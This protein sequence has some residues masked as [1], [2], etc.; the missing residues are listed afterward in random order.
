MKEAA[1][2]LAEARAEM[3]AAIAEKSAAQEELGQV[4]LS[5]CRPCP[6]IPFYRILQNV[7][8]GNVR[9]EKSGAAP[10]RSD[11]A[12]KYISVLSSDYLTHPSL[13]IILIIILKYARAE[14]RVIHLAFPTGAAAV[15]G[16]RR[17]G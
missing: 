7:R 13:S 17:G 15:G 3:Q 10:L 5:R 14:T 9:E 1:A 16:I 6:A 2:R 12:K 8:S 4:S 11:T